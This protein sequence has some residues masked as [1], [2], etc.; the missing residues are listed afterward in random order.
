M[1][2]MAS[3]DFFTVPTAS[4][5]IL[6]VLVI[7]SH[8][9]RKVVHFNVPSNPTAMWTAYQVMEAFPWDTVPRYLLRDR[10]PIYE[11]YFPIN[12]AGAS[13]AAMAIDCAKGVI[14]GVVIKDIILG[15]P[16]FLL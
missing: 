8:S 15:I 10:D 9:R 16:L 1:K 13:G 3:I 12:D 7:L 5:R 4:F 14:S 11:S 6:F 2:S